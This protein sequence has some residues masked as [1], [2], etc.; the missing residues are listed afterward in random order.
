MIKIPKCWVCLDRGFIPYQ[1][2]KGRN[3]IAYCT[4]KEGTGYQIN[5]LDL[6]RYVPCIDEN[7]DKVEVATQNLKEFWKWNKEDQSVKRE[8][9]ASGIKTSLLE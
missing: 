9:E 7:F 6:K 8:L 1:D 5:D 3:Y 4:C 2:K